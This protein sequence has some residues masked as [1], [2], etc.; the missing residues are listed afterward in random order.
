MM[1]VVVSDLDSLESSRKFLVSYEETVQ[2][3]KPVKAQKE[4]N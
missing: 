4:P 2:A 3:V 1:T